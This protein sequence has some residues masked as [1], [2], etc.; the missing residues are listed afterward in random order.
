M[1][2]WIF[3]LLVLAN[4]GMFLWGVQYLE[5][6]R[7]TPS[8]LPPDIRPEQMQLVS[9]MPPNA[10]TARP[11]PPPPPPTPAPAPLAEG[12]ICYRLGPV[13]DAT[14]AMNLERALA[15]QALAFTKREEPGPRIIIYR[16]YLPPFA[17]KAEAERKRRDLTRLGFRDHALIQEEGFHNAISLGLF[18]V[19]ANAQNHMRRL[20]EKGIKAQMQTQEQVRTVFWFELAPVVANDLPARLKPLL[21]PI[22]GARVGDIPCPAPVQPPSPTSEP[23]GA[24]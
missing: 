19:E 13:A 1:R 20:A 22:A 24:G 4:V 12:R 6:E 8:Q 15:A 2:R 18:T 7:P 10:L 9:E 23:A 17:S 16:V 5:P 21:E 14:Q 11:K 3:A